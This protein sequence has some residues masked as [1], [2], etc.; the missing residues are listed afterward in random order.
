MRRAATTAVV[1]PRARE[2]QK[3]SRLLAT[4]LVPLRAV[5]LYTLTRGGGQVTDEVTCESPRMRGGANDLHRSSTWAGR[6]STGL[7]VLAP[8]WIVPDLRP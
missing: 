8:R 1:P 7:D 6:S 3:L 4:P 2:L 5:V